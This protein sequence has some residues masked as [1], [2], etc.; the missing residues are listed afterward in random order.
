MVDLPPEIAA[1]LAEIPEPSLEAAYEA[2]LGVP[3]SDR[4]DV[5]VEAVFGILSD[6]PRLLGAPDDALNAGDSLSLVLRSVMP[7]IRLEMRRSDPEDVE[8][9]VCAVLGAALSRVA[10][11]GVPFER[12]ARY[13]T[14][15]SANR[16]ER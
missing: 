10:E 4:R 3:P 6:L 15:A 7:V 2:L 13:M 5:L 9:G 1:Q 12:I 16:H 8:R 11:A 14:Q